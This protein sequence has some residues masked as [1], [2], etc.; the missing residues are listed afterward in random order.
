VAAHDVLDVLARADASSHLPRLGGMARASGVVIATDRFWAYAAADGSVREGV[1]PGRA[2]RFRRIPLVRGLVRLGSSLAPLAR[3]RGVASGRERLFLAVAVVAPLLLFLLPHGLQLPAGLAVSAG[4]VF[5]MLRGRTLRLHGAE[6]RAIAAVEERRLVETWAGSAR[7]TRF[8][9]RCGTN[10][11]ALALPVTLAA[12]RLWPLPAVAVLTPVFVA[13]FSLALTMELWV[14]VQASERRLARALLVPGLA[15]QR[16]TTREP[17]LDDTRLAL[18]A[19]A[20]VL[21][22]ELTS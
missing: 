10:F 4:L 16:L 20:A 19:A 13:L 8:A 3:G 15:L 11:A 18:V 2:G 14:L 5:W 17:E 6:H 9:A 1:M 22:R 12:E 7:P 21:R